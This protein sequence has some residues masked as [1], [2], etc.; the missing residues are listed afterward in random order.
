VGGHGPTHDATT[1]DV[2]NDGQEQE[3]GHRR[4]DVMSATH[5]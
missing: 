3:A 4:D 5:S 1:E 2:E